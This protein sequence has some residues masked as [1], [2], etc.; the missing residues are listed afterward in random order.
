MHWRNFLLFSVVLSALI[1]SGCMSA[2]E[3]YIHIRLYSGLEYKGLLQKDDGEKVSIKTPYGERSFR[4]TDIVSTSRNFSKQEKDALKSA[5]ATVADPARPSTPVVANAVDAFRVKDDTRPASGRGFG[6]GMGSNLTPYERMSRGLDK[7]V[8]L[9]FVDTPLEEAMSFLASLTNLNII[10][11]PKVRESK[12]VVTLRMQ[13]MDAGTTIKWITR[14]TETHAELKDQ[15]I[16]I[17][18]KPS[19][20]ADDEERAEIMMLAGSLKAEVD[21]PPE[22]VPLT[23]ADRTKI[24][25]QLWQK[26]QP[27]IT[28]FPGPDISIGAAERGFE[29]PFAV[30]PGE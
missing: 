1:C 3:D 30:A 4:K 28:H 17:T 26:E 14:L 23:D 16:W 24:A 5:L 13:N 11:S 8:S 21:L 10:V 15:A 22:G 25:L 27:K 9:E 2:E 20:E 19:K 12:P 7:K 29:N 6:E 18:D